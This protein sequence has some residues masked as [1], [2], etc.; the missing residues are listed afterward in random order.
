MGFSRAVEGAIGMNYL[1]EHHYLASSYTTQE[2]IS[3]S[4]SIFFNIT[5]ALTWA[6]LLIFY[7]PFMPSVTPS[8]QYVERSFQT[9]I[10]WSTHPYG[11]LQYFPYFQCAYRGLIGP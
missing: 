5:M 1:Q 3:P 6:P 4:C 9:Q 11:I 7:V 8:N 2:S 10:E